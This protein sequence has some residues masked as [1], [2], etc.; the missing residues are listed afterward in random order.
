MFLFSQALES[1]SES[2][3]NR[4][5]SCRSRYDI[6]VVEPDRD[7]AQRFRDRLEDVDGVNSV[8]VVPDGDAA[9]EFVSR[10]GE[11][12]DAPVPNLVLLELDLPE[13]SGYEI[14]SE[15]KTAPESRPIPIIVMSNAD[16]TESVSRSYE[17]SANAHVSKPTSE[18]E[19]ERFVRLLETFWF[20]MAQLPQ[21]S[22]D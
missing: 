12:A 22:T 8:A 19:F 9:R 2:E 6:L 17:H 18:A 7:V 5:C 1:D 11:Y 13:T 14:L 16:D 20:D 3:V 15:L 4:Y 10:R 21:P